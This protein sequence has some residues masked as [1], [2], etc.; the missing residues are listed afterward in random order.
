MGAGLLRK[1]AMMAIP[2]VIIPI[3]FRL[4]GQTYVVYVMTLILFWAYLAQ[5]WNIVWG[6][7]G[8]LSFG[9]A[10]FLGIGAYVSTLLFL[11][12]GL[13]PWIGM[14]VGG[15]AAISLA[16]LIGY[17]TLRLRGV[18]FALATIAVA[19]MVRLLT[20]KLD[21]ITGGSL[22]LLLPIT[23]SPLLF[24]FDDI[25]H[26]Y[27]MALVMLLV[28]SAV[29]HSIENS[30]LGMALRAVKGEEDA[31]ASVGIYPFKYKMMALLLS[32]FFTAIGGT[33]FAQLTGY[34]RPDIIL[35]V[36]RSEEIL[37]IALVG[38]TGTFIGPIIGAII[39]LSLR[40]TI[41][42]LLG[43]GYAGVHLVIYGILIIL[44]VRFMPGGVYQYLRSGLGKIWR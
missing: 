16:L 37:T 24:Q 26:W 13:T 38:G 41:L 1:L 15:V 21:F 11:N 29:S 7:A 4:L 28:L 33:F 12:Y 27:L 3:L 31:A 42:A 14:F 43:G 6:Y 34:I 22:G 8:L 39:L 2:G 20:L 18:Y 44:V 36:E 32:A 19:E 5:C 25:L 17:P 35:T 40:Q 9:H 30:K 23:R 10:A